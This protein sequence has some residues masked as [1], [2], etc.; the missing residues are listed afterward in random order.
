MTARVILHPALLQR[1]PA[2]DLVR[3]FGARGFVLSNV[4]GGV[5]AVPVP[6]LTNVVPIRAANPFGKSRVDS[7][8]EFAKRPQ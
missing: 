2:G 1:F 3:S 7:F 5:E 8:F 6:V 4:R